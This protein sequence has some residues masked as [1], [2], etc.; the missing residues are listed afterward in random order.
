MSKR[1]AVDVGGPALLVST[2]SKVAWR[3]G[4]QTATTWKCPT[5]RFTEI[6]V[7]NDP[8]LP[9]TALPTD[10]DPIESSTV[11]PGLQPWPVAVTGPPG[12]VEL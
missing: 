7:R 8:S 2:T 6:G 4:P 1:A 11:L 9:A 10:T 3:V 12:G 5:G